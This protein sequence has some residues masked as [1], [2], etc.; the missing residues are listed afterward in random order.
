[1]DERRHSSPCHATRQWN[2]DAS[3]PQL[4]WVDDVLR[5]TKEEAVERLCAEF[6]AWSEDLREDDLHDEPADRSPLF[7]RNGVDLHWAFDSPVAL[8]GA[9]ELMGRD[10]LKCC[11]RG[12]FSGTH[13]INRIDR[14]AVMAG[15]VVVEGRACVSSQ[16]A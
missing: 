11:M 1:M 6:R 16:A 3:T 13:V 8:A 9:L 10:V 7:E 5:V 14:I 4:E 15:D 12:D 2:S